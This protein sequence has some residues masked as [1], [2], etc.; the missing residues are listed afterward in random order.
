M[1]ARNKGA[2]FRTCMIMA[3]ALAGLALM[4]IVSQAMMRNQQ[5]MQPQP[6][7]QMP[8]QTNPQGWGRTA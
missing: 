6:M 4:M 1:W 3:M 8:Q 2:A 7:G 5:P